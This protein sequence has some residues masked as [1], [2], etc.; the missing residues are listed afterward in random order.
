M[1]SPSLSIGKSYKIPANLSSPKLLIPFALVAFG[2]AGPLH[3]AAI[4]SILSIGTVLVPPYP[5]NTSAFGLLTASLRT[6]LSTTLLVQSDDPEALTKL[7]NAL[8][9]LRERTL[10]TLSR[11]GFTGEPEVEQ[12][13]EMRYFGQNYHREVVFSSNAPIDQSDFD[14]AAVEAFNADYKSFY[15]YDT[16]GELVEVGRA[17]RDS[18]RRAPRP[19]GTVDERNG[20]AG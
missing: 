15:G 6:D 16:P 4:A 20:G 10:A 18:E 7:N 11:E 1:A 2:G 19:G 13:F 14:A 17:C 8:V 5:G 12:R 3:T 9:P